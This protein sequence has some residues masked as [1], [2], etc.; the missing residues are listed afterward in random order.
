M[1]DLRCTRRR[2][3]GRIGRRQFGR[4]ALA[5]GASLAAARAGL[6]F[7]EAAPSPGERRVFAHYMV[8]CPMAGLDADAGDYLP[9]LRQAQAMGIDAFALNVGGWRKEPIYPAVTGRLFSAAQSLG[10]GFK[11]FFSV[12]GLDVDEAVAMLSA[13][14]DHPAHFRY[15]GKPLLSTYSGDAEWA[16]ALLAALARAKRPVV[17]VPGFFPRH[18]GERFSQAGVRQLIA[19]NPELDGFFYFGGAGTGEEIAERSRR[20]GAAWRG[21]GKLYMAPVTPYY[22]GTGGNYRLFE[23]RGFEGMAQQ[24]ESAIE[25]GAQWVE[26][27]TWN[28]WGESTYVASFGP[29]D[30]TSLWDGR[31]GPILS[32]AGYL[33]A[34]QYY[35]R[36]FKT[37]DQRVERDQL[38]WFYRLASRTQPG[39]RIPEGKAQAFPKGAGR[40]EDRV[41]ASAFLTA[42]AVLH[43]ESGG[44]SYQFPL[45]A[46]VHHVA[47]DFDPGPQRFALERAGRRILA[48]EGAFPIAQDNWSNFNYLSGEARPV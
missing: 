46:G 45:E 20:I 13:Y 26:I 23:T 39:R 14:Y 5:A 8:C 41:F 12:D 21:A 9:E 25:A 4:Y 1:T 15:G 34:S 16:T 31:W 35:I 24:W 48:G 18:S 3:F 7:A 10:T 22:R 30:A 6:G 33:A 42:P 40:L 37:G 29:P 17:F 11:L 27:V 28:D 19:E 44:R 38:F 2:I 36:W 43:I 32:H 47:A